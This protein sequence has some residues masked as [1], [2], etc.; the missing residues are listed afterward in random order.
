MNRTAAI[1]LTLGIMVLPCLSQSSDEPEVVV[2]GRRLTSDQL[3]ALKSTTG[4][5][6]Q[7]GCYWYDPRSG[8]Y[9]LC[10]R[11]TAGVL[12]PG[13][14]DFGNAAP[15]ASR[16]NTGLFLN[17][18]ELNQVE[19]AFFE[20]LFGPIAPGRWWL[21]GRNGNIGQEGSRTVRGN[22]VAAL[23]QTR[24]PSRGDDSYLWRD[25]QGSVAGSD[26][27]CTYMSV[28]GSNVYMTPGCN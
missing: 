23:R 16:G 27:T 22:L 8:F 14:M 21:D 26:G 1:L 18:R 19:K 13:I 7:T 28:P 10:G 2:N 6:P 12:Q 25:G 11:E 17:G 3:L 9:G 4:V 5:P 24:K 15:N 20:R